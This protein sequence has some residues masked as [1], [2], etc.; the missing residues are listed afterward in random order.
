MNDKMLEHLA[1][2]VNMLYAR[3]DNMLGPEL[4][5]C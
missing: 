1:A 2:P 3:D 5:A 4:A